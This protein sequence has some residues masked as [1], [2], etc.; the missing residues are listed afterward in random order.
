MCFLQSNVG[1]NV[2]LATLTDKMKRGKD[3]VTADI[4][5]YKT[6]RQLKPASGVRTTAAIVLKDTFL[7]RKRMTPPAP[8]QI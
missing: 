8:T 3:E 6:G 7:L 4:Q 2:F 5:N 1:V